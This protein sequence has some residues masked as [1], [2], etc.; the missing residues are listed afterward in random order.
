[1]KNKRTNNSSQNENAPEIP[2][3]ASTKKGKRASKNKK[4]KIS[5]WLIFL[6]IVSAS[7]GIVFLLYENIIIE[8]YK[9]QIQELHSIIDRNKLQMQELNNQIANLDSAVNNFQKNPQEKPKS[10]EIQSNTKPPTIQ[11]TPNRS[12]DH[13]LNT[14]IKKGKALLTADTSDSKTF[15]EYD[16]W[17]AECISLLRQIDKEQSSDHANN[18]ETLTKIDMADYPQLPNKINDGINT[19]TGIK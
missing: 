17:R 7:V 12:W 19:L 10:N 3:N 14:L 13:K 6:S 18:F 11:T 1:M 5:D 4:L 16:S 9:F 15:T 8:R 2:D